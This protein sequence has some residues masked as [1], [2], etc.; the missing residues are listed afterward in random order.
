MKKIILCASLLVTAAIFTVQAADRYWISNT[1]GNW[2]NAANWSATSGG[3]GGASVPDTADVV[4][5]DAAGTG[6]C[7]IDVNVAVNGINVTAGYTGAISQNNFFITVG[8][9]NASFSG[10]TFLG[11]N[12]DFTCNGNFTLNGAD[13]IAPSASLTITGNYTFSSGTLN[14]NTGTVVLSGANTISGISHTLYNLTF[15]GGTYTLDVD[16][17]VVGTLRYSGTTAINVNTANNNKLFV[18]GD[19]EISNT[20]T[21][22]GGSSFVHIEGTGNQTITSTVA[23]GRG[24]LPNVTLNKASGDL[25]VVGA[26][27][28]RRTW[29]YMSGTITGT[30]MIVF[31]NGNTLQG[32]PHTIPAV[33]FMSGIHNLNVDITVSGTL[34]YNSTSI[35]GTLINTGNSS[36]LLV[37]GDIEISNTFLGAGSSS[38]H[39]EGTGNQTITSTVAIG[40]GALPNVTLNKTSGDLNV[41]GMVS[42][43][44][45][46]TYVQG[47]ITGAGT[48][49][50]M[51]GNLLQGP[52]H[53]IPSV[54]FANG[55]CNL[56]TNIDV[57]DNLRITGNTNVILNSGNSSNIYVTGDITVD[58]TA[59]GGGGNATVYITGSGNTNFYTSSPCGSGKL[60]NVIFDKP[61]GSMTIVQQAANAAMSVAG[62]YTHVQGTLTGGTPCFF[63]IDA[64]ITHVTCNELNNGA[65][66]I[67]I[68]GGTPPYTFD[69]GFATTEDVQNLSAGTYSVTVTDADNITGTAT[70]TVSEPTV[71][72]ETVINP[73]CMGSNDGSI[74]VNVTGGTAP[75]A[76]IWSNNETSHS[77]SGLS[78][79]TYQLT[80]IDANG[81]SVTGVFELAPSAITIQPDIT[82]PSCGSNDGAIEII[83]TGG[84]GI[85]EFSLDGNNYQAGNIFTNLSE[86][87]YTVYVR[88]ENECVAFSTA[89]LWRINISVD[90]IIKTDCIAATGSIT[91]SA[92]GGTP[93][94]TFTW[95]NGTAGMVNDNL[96]AGWYSVTVEDA[97]GCRRHKN[98]EAEY[99]DTCRSLISGT[100]FID[101]NGNCIKDAGEP[102]MRNLLIDISPGGGT[103]TNS[104]GN[105]S[106]SIA[107]GNYVLTPILSGNVFNIA[108]I[109]CLP[110]GS[111]SVTADGLNDF[112]NNIFALEYIPY[113]DVGVTIATSVARP[114]FQQTITT[115]VFNN[116][117]SVVSGVLKVTLDSRTT[118]VSSLNPVADSINGQ[119]IYFHYDFPE[120]TLNTAK[121]FSIKVN[122][123]TPPSININDILNYEAQVFP[124]ENDGIAR[125]NYFILPVIVTG[126]YDPNDKLVTPAGDFLEQDSVFLY[127]IRFQNTGNDTAFTVVIRDTLDENLNVKSII[128]VAASHEYEVAIEEENILVFTFFNILL[129]DSFVNEPES[130]GF[131]Q[132]YIT[133]KPNLTIGTTIAN[134]A[135]IYFDYNEPIITNTVVNTLALPVGISN[136]VS[137][138]SNQ[139]SVYPNPANNLVY[140]VQKNKQVA[141]Y[142][143]ELFDLSGRT[144]LIVEKENT[145]NISRLSQGMYI[146]RVQD[147]DG[148]M[149]QGKI[150]RK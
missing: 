145:I 117:T 130:H 91:V 48:I 118:Y 47:T 56:L 26:V 70:F 140:F 131:V 49:A 61:G 21:S 57:T 55:T 62:T 119:D 146:Y 97:D 7:N 94:Y 92:T 24:G 86:G 72:S 41:I 16:I 102:E 95:G 81:C 142:K 113:H 99:H 59:T 101:L 77:I 133:R 126:A 122:I 89:A 6:N 98:I 136:Q 85:L 74:I 19:I 36:K 115:T 11:G 44:G 103:F 105:Y 20:S 29:T 96:N 110:S 53:T 14:P 25:F 104:N 75:F 78:E 79:G 80:I 42:V 18:H 1:A 73:S 132:F 60:P 114:G 137:D 87:D 125:N 135:A 33:T 143:I 108:E 123:A 28:I 106:V 150:L 8:T 139:I 31:T 120:G 121:Q 46:W 83:A 88:D 76:F 43:G 90:T 51:N 12:A 68:N 138:I 23:I 54:A 67:T 128:P 4:L 45:T 64:V 69:W 27:S 50:F 10:G 124:G 107:P 13:F 93:P 37:H 30:G 111:I 58:N 84:T 3:S 17:T 71:F 32:L 129:P 149:Y 82:Q 34:R 148:I 144:M 52:P 35:I 100:V 22:G 127:T 38:I 141:L 66:D 147:S 40:Q 39:I 63:N 109:V 2:N 65:I 9:S 15:L 134:T 5:F 116:S 112:P